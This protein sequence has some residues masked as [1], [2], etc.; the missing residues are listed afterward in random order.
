MTLWKST[1]GGTTWLQE[2]SNVGYTV[3]GY[4]TP[5]IYAANA[6]PGVSVLYREGSI[7]VARVLFKHATQDH[8]VEYSHQIPGYDFVRT[9]FPGPQALEQFGASTELV[10]D[11]VSGSLRPRAFL[12]YYNYDSAAGTYNLYIT[13]GTLYS[14]SV[15]FATVKALTTAPS[16]TA[17]LWTEDSRQFIGEYRDSSGGRG[18]HHHPVWIDTRP[19]LAPPDATVYVSFVTPVY[20]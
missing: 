8:Q 5:N 9:T 16:F 6:T 14:A 1:D 7:G 13:L 11:V 10:Q 17:E 19:S 12:S 2:M 15:S 18:L 3:N 4:V 20:W